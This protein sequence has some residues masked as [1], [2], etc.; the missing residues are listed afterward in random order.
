[1]H[2]SAVQFMKTFL[3]ALSP[4]LFA[5]TLSLSAVLIQPESA[6]AQAAIAP[7][8]GQDFHVT[9]EKI[10]ELKRSLPKT[11]EA[12]IFYHWTSPEVGMRWMMQGHINQGE[13]DFY[14]TPTGKLQSYGAG[15]YMA[16]SKTSSE[17]FGDFCV[18]FKME[19]GTLVY[20]DEVATKVFG[21]RLNNDE[22]T[23]L[24]K[25]VP[26]IR[27]LNS[28]W[29]I[30]HNSANLSHVEYGGVYGADAKIFKAT[31]QLSL[32]KAIR[33]AKPFGDSANYLESF[34][35]LMHYM[36]GISLQRA[37]RVAPENPWSQFEPHLFENFKKLNEAALTPAPNARRSYYWGADGQDQEAWAD[38]QVVK[39]VPAILNGLY[40]THN[41]AYRGHGIRAGGTNAG[42]TFLGSPQELAALLANPYLSVQHK[43][44]PSGHG[45][46]ISYEY[47]SIHDYKRLKPLLS[48]DVYEWLESFSPATLAHDKALESRLNQRII[49]DLLRN[50]FREIHGKPIDPADFLQK[51]V[52]IHPF[53]DGNGRTSRLYL[54]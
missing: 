37:I 35:H 48:A 54:Q 13:V 12:K 32:L 42:A 53:S 28:D 44:D 24:G 21:R 8:L 50:L 16:T 41:A 10:E 9:H 33:A 2:K 22:M 6:R 27:D 15:I 4:L 23:E 3:T 38:A 31:D 52:S 34:F 19:P 18:V 30:T 40:E 49:E 39:E 20:N 14:N 46:L 11:T 36:D 17:G 7:Q 29:H 43:P 5:A 47:P 51:F 1:M 26:F 45:F 25:S